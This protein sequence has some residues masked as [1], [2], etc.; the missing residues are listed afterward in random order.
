MKNLIIFSI[1]L[2]SFI[3]C[4]NNINQEKIKI[5]NI[6][7]F[8]SPDNKST[9]YLYTVENGMAFGSNFNLLEIVPINK[10][11]KFRLEH[12]IRLYNGFPYKIQW[13]NNTLT[14]YCSQNNKIFIHKN[15]NYKD[16]IIN[17]KIVEVFS[18]GLSDTIFVNNIK[19]NNKA[20]IINDSINLNTDSLQVYKKS[21]EYIIEYFYIDKNSDNNKISIDNY[22]LK[23]KDKN[24]SILNKLQLINII[25]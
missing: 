14:L 13:T 23:N 16:N 12:S 4:E 15:Y 11:P 20:L 18:G 8:N 6:E 10:K 25:K 9:A 3:S 2:F 1:I 5:N 7:F 22:I 19:L 24:L 17:E 21:S